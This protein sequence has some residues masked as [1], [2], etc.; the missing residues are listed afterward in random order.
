MKIFFLNLISIL[1]S[2]FTNLS[3]IESLRIIF[4]S[5]YVLFLPGFIM[6]YI[7]FSKTKEF[8]SEEKESNSIDWIERIA[9]SFALSIA[10]VPLAVFY[11]NLVGVN[12][13]VLIQLPSLIW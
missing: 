11:V 7:F 9:L 2:G 3:Y 12:I 1:I 8:D 13:K 6:S 5:V 4:G 10:F